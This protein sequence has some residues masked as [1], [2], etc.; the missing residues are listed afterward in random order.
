MTAAPRS[1]S[2]LIETLHGGLALVNPDWRVTFVSDRFL[3]FAGAGPALLGRDLRELFTTIRDLDGE[4]VHP[5]LAHPTPITFDQ[6]LVG[7]DGDRRWARIALVPTSGLIDGVGAVVFAKDTTATSRAFERLRSATLRLTDVEDELHRKVARELH[8]GPIQMLSALGIHLDLVSDPNATVEIRRLVSSV[9]DEL[10][11]AITDFTRFHEPTPAGSLLG[12]WIAPFLGSSI[13]FHVDASLAEPY[14][15]ALTQAAFVFTYELVRAAR[16]I[17]R[18]RVL[19]VSLADDGD[20]HRIVLAITA[21]T[22]HGMRTGR[23]GAQ[24]R[25]VI[26]FAESLGGTLS[27]RVDDEG[28]LTLSVWIPKR[29][30][31]E[32]PDVVDLTAGL[33]EQVDPT[34]DGSLEIAS[35]PP[36][37]NAGWEH[38]ARAC[39]EQILEFDADARF[40]FVNTAQEE[41]VGAGPDELVGVEFSG[42]FPPDAVETIR[43]DLDRLTSGETIDITWVRENA[44]G[45][46]RT[47]R[48]VATPRV[49]PDGTV[50]GAL[51][52]VDDV[53]DLEYLSHLHES[54]LADLTRARRLATEASLARLDGPLTAA[55]HLIARLR[56]FEFAT[57][58]P[59]VFRSMRISLQQT[60]P[61]VRRSLGALASNDLSSD[62]LGTTLR[63]SLSS[64]M[65][66]ARLIFIDK[67]DAAPPGAT[68]D[69][70][71]RIAREAVINAI[72]HGQANVITVTLRTVDDG[73][74]LD[75]HDNGIGVDAGDL[76]PREGHL[77][78]RAMRERASE[79]GGWCR[80]EQH[81]EGGTMV[82]VRLPLGDE[83]PTLLGDAAIPVV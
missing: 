83:P 20:G 12:R 35:L 37:S 48:V 36:L 60:L 65:G 45:D 58:D 19:D 81:A 30:V 24:F 4:G 64:L 18:R 9:G 49:E 29:A 76:D 23:V 78:T 15:P 66:R 74:E 43:P 46:P 75:V 54:A 68:V 50:T 47:V 17:G 44:L 7:A 26:D 11:E 82:T 42:F 13:E 56:H 6:Q 62:E 52:V 61:A 16:H 39:P 31:D 14:D 40:S 3:P 71:F 28:L 22:E 79:R 25:A 5:D 38:I 53:G 63:A 77:G 21:A 10:R 41:L 67:T 2:E 27:A 8:D 57:P 73:I 59:D 32:L 80:I 33:D 72:T 34:G 55:E 1:W 70:L 51:S 69:V